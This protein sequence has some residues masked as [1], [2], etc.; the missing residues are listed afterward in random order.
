MLEQTSPSYGGLKLGLFV[1]KCGLFAQF[2]RAPFGK[3]SQKMATKRLS[4]RDFAFSGHVSTPAIAKVR[5]NAFCC[6][7]LIFQRTV[8]LDFRKGYRQL[9]AQCP[10]YPPPPSSKLSSPKL[11]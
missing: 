5:Q 11:L 2:Q 9:Q 4:S 6:L 7:I 1:T 3:S 8:W 10:E